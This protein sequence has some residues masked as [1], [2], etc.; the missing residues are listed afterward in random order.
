MLTLC[1][2]TQAACFREVARLLKPGGYFACYEW[3]MT[4][5]FDPENKTHQEIKFGIEVGNSL[6]PM[7]TFAEV[8]QAVA[9]AGLELVEAFDAN[10]GIKDPHQLPWYTT[11]AGGYTL[12]GFKHTMLGMYMSHTLV[13]TLET[14]RVAPAGS[15]KVHGMLLTVASELRRGGETGIFT[16][17]YFFLARK[18]EA[19]DAARRSSTG[20]RK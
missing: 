12:D 3:A 16:P 20:T 15:T 6:P 17:G 2:W 19:A 10:A 7:A 11:L 4:E 8:R 1:V 5:L 9:D 14:L 18:P 13:S